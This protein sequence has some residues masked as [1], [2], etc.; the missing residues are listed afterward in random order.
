MAAPFT[1]YFCRICSPVYYNLFYPP[2]STAAEPVK[3]ALLESVIMINGSNE[4]ETGNK[5]RDNCGCLMRRRELY[6]YRT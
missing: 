1:K 5:N 4:N 6:G 3:L 2:L